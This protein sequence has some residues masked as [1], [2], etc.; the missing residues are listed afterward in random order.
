M[1]QVLLEARE[2]K[3]GLLRDGN[4]T[5][6]IISSCQEIAEL[7]Y[8]PIPANGVEDGSKLNGSID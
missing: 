5:L 1:S 2:V 6:V 8:S 4:V 3:L 7:K